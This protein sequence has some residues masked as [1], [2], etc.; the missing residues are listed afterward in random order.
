MSTM[1]DRPAP[2]R[3]VEA[4]GATYSLMD[5]CRLHHLDPHKAKIIMTD[6]LKLTVVTAEV[7]LAEYA[8]LKEAS[9]HT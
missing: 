5:F 7:M 3:R 8:K 4:R 2:R 6:I 9:V 1:I